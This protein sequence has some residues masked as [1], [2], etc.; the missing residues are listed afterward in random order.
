MRSQLVA[1]PTYLLRIVLGF[2]NRYA[3]PWM[4]C[5]LTKIEGYPNGLAID[6]E[7]EAALDRVPAPAGFSRPLPFPDVV[8][9]EA[10]LRSSSDRSR[11]GRDLS[12]AS[13]SVR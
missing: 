9:R 1:T 11:A 2:H 3:N 6:D 10:I 5:L 12:D 13:R 4:S 8:Q 7:R